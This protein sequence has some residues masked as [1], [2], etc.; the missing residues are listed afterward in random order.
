L[1]GNGFPF[2]QGG[3]G[4]ISGDDT[5]YYLIEV[6]DGSGNVSRLVL[7]LMNL[8]GKGSLDLSDS[9]S[10]KLVFET[11]GFVADGKWYNLRKTN[12]FLKSGDSIAIWNFTKKQFK[13]MQSPD[14]KCQIILDPSAQINSKLIAVRVKKKEE[15]AW[16]WEPPIPL[17]KKVK[18]KVKIPENGKF[19]SLYEKN[20]NGW[21]F[22]SS[23]V[24]GDYMV[25]HVDHLGVF[26]IL[27][28]S[29][30]PIVSLGRKYFSS[31]TPLQINVR[32]SLSGV[33]FYSIKTLIDDKQTVFRY[34]P[35]IERLI[36][37]HPEEISKGKHKLSLSLSDKQ[38][39]KIARAWEIVKK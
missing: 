23:D 5:G 17:K 15:I 39:N 21:S 11:N 6:Y 22:C 8:K 24:E 30:P 13:T 33:D 29:I 37:E 32:D 2:Y 35:Q 7:E 28:D 1:P 19:Y 4:I 34:D 36:C 10:K 18:I 14:G 3:D 31:K 26:C 27:K 20:R 25:D 38:G 9:D 12:G 16:S